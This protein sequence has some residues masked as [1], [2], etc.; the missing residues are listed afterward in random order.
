MRIG[1]EGMSEAFCKELVQRMTRNLTDIQI[2][3]LLEVQPLWGYRIKKKVE[4]DLGVKLR[5]GTLYPTLSL[6]ETRGFVAGEKQQYGGRAR[7]VYSITEEGRK[8]LQSYYTIIR[9][10]LA[11]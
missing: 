3:R 9:E 11:I 2:L 8:Y 5:H 7:K 6:L 4:L 1:A 10:Q